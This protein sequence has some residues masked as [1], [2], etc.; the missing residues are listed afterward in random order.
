MPAR[1]ALPLPAAP[2]TQK[3]SPAEAGLFSGVEDDRSGERV[4]QDDG[5][6]AVGAGGDEGDAAAG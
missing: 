4:V 1:R 6:V 5:V 3:K 2:I